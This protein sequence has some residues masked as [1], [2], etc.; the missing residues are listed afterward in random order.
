MSRIGVRPSRDDDLPAIQRIYAHHVLTSVAS[1]EVAPPD[2]AELARR[3]AEV[4]ARGLPYLVVEATGGPPLGYAYASPYRARPAYRHTVE[5]S[6]Y[7]APEA[8]GRGC[9]R[10]LLAALI[11]ACEARD[12][13]EIVAVIADRAN[14][15]SIR[16]HQALG[17]REVGCLEGVGFKFGRWI[18][19]ILMQCS[20]NGEKPPP[21][22]LFPDR[23]T[24]G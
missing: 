17:F 11:A 21:P 2:V 24:T 10:A 8:L 3:R 13:R 16:L 14:A 7:V 20:I 5:D 12:V 6:L 15:P 22:E 4:L 9:G 1:F 18:D 19:T 23:L